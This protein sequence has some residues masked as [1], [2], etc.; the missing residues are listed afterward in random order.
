MMKSISL[1]LFLSLLIHA[2]SSAA[3]ETPGGCSYSAPTIMSG[4]NEGIIGCDAALIA[5]K[6][7]EKGEREYKRN[8]NEKMAKSVALQAKQIFQDLGTTSDFYEGNNQ[9]FLLSGDVKNQCKFDF[10]A[11]IEKNG[12][13]GKKATAEEKEKM[14]MLANALGETDGYKSKSLWDSFLHIYG[15]NK[16]GYGFEDPNA[17][18]CPLNG[19]AFSL[20]SIITVQS[21]KNIIDLF[22]LGTSEAVAYLYNQYP[23]LSM[24]K[25]AEKYSPG[26]QEK[27]EKYIKGYDANQKSPKDYLSAFFFDK[28]NSEI[29][30]RG[31]ASRCGQVRSSVSSFV[32]HS[33]SNMASTDPSISKKLFNN[34]DPRKEFQD[35]KDSVKADPNAYKS[36]AYLCLAKQNIKASNVAPAA[37]SENSIAVADNNFCQNLK[38]QDDTVDNWYKC[39]N[40]GRRPEGV[41]IS[42]EES[43]NLFCNRFSCKSPETKNTNSCKAGGPLSAIDLASLN[44]AD[45]RIENQIAYLEILEKHKRSRSGYLL[46]DSTTPGPSTLP[47][48]IKKGLSSFDMNAFGA[49]AVSKLAGLPQT[50]ETI[51]L[52]IQDMKDK[53]IQPSTPEDV[54]R[55]VNR[56]NFDEAVAAGIRG[57][58]AVQSN[59]AVVTA[60]NEPNY[61]PMINNHFAPFDKNESAYE[62][63]KT[64][65]SPF[66]GGAT[67]AVANA[68]T[69]QMIKDL[70]TLMEANKKSD[71]E[72]NHSS[73]NKA[74][75]STPAKDTRS[76]YED[77]LRSWANRL[78]TKDSNLREREN[79][80]NIRDA[81]YWQKYEELKRK[82][83]ELAAKAED[84]KKSRGPASVGTSG[85]STKSSTAHALQEV[86]AA[87]A[88]LD[89]DLIA[90]P[91]GL[92][93]TPERLEKLDKDDLKEN[94]VNIEEPFVISV[95]LKSKLIHVRVAKLKNGNRSYLAP[96][97]N[98]DNAEVKEAILKSPI[99]KEF[100]YF[101]EQKETAYTPVKKV[102]KR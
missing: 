1:V 78:S 7:D 85:A 49:E 42:D 48:E 45:D 17:N 71:N 2:H 23:Q 90:T 77:E 37:K 9:S 22:T 15:S 44:I 86:K 98:E 74:I 40:E 94:H 87:K 35:Q 101:M 21:A 29:L 89:Q 38:P 34:Y 62:R 97:L 60:S 18:Q 19:N 5:L 13:D 76:A 80:A 65:S 96:Y 70:K 93:V 82:E 4:K 24:I 88:K 30:G 58:Q 66:I 99:F 28:N 54:Q 31:V 43:I 102:T 6:S 36:Y 72:K 64:S 55:I 95:R 73:Y 63:P 57:G 47:D 10:I 84:E 79:L 39:F 46:G 12:C 11:Q 81:E 14:E 8:L 59:N 20:H 3:E 50:Q 53:G 56:S 16:Y 26:F 61:Q 92:T 91:A 83:A 25:E 51:A 41:V 69:E 32:C 100:R 27:F 68:E 52:V 75:E 67:S 33:I